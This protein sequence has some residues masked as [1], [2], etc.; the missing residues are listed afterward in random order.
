M[1]DIGAPVP[2]RMTPSNA[3]HQSSGNPVEDETERL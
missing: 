2:N 1:G 3:S